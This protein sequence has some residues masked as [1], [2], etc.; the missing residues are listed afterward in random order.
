MALLS[1]ASPPAPR[2]GAR[3][4]APA[5]GPGAWPRRPAADVLALVASVAAVLAFALA[6]LPREKTKLVPTAITA[7][8]PVAPPCEGSACPAEV[9]SLAPNSMSCDSATEIVITGRRFTNAL[10]VRLDDPY[11]TDLPI[12]SG[13]ETE[14]RVRAPAGLTPGMYC[15][16]VTTPFGKNTS[17]ADQLIVFCSPCNGCPDTVNIAEVTNLNTAFTQFL[18]GDVAVKYVIADANQGRYDIMAE[19]STDGLL[20]KTATARP[21]GVHSGVTGL[22]S[23]P[24]GATFFF[25][26]DSYADLGNNDYNPVT[27][28]ITPKNRIDGTPV[29][30]KAAQ[31]NVGVRDDYPLVALSQPAGVNFGD[32]V[33][34]FALI[35]PQSRSLAYL[36]DYSPD[37]GASWLPATESTRGFSAGLAAGPLAAAPGNGAGYGFAWNSAQDLPRQRNNLVVFRVRRAAG[38][39]SAASQTSAFTVDNTLIGAASN[40]GLFGAPVISDL[41][42]LSGD[43]LGVNCVDLAA[44]D[45]NGDGRD[46]VVVADV[47][48]SKVYALRSA[49]DGSFSTADPILV[50]TNPTTQNTQPV[51]VETL[52]LGGDGFLDVVAMASL[53]SSCDITPLRG[54]GNGAFTA[55]TPIRTVPEAQ[56]TGGAY[57]QPTK[58]ITADFNGD[59]RT[60]VA[61]V[62]FTTAAPKKDLVVLLGD[63]VGGFRAPIYLDTGV[64]Q[65]LSLAAGDF[66]GDGVPDLCV[67]NWRGAPSVQVRVLIGENDGTGKGTG[68]FTPEPAAALLWD[69]AGRRNTPF[70]ALAA[71]FDASGRADIAICPNPNKLGDG[72]DE[73]VLLANDG[74]GAFTVRSLDSSSLGAGP[75][76]GIAGDLDGDGRP[77]LAFSNYASHNVAILR[78]TG[79]G[80]LSPSYQVSSAE[81]Y[82][83]GMAGGY[84]A[85]GDFN[86]DG[87][88]DL[89]VAQVALPTQGLVSVLLR[90]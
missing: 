46:D 62:T 71:D 52:Q 20:F 33:V 17:C 22:L 13:T 16:R 53:A 65:A 21:G 5:G 45:F 4:R 70:M 64:A 40:S 86:G 1:P 34:Q 69:V 79:A 88:K 11:Q 41:A 24:A 30:K 72:G 35:D 10:S 73:Y 26:W 29:T 25:V 84:L 57:N 48:T 47:S 15:L 36:A 9:L 51:H 90:K 3:S 6:C 83:V 81:T 82:D 32:V 19:Y 56:F 66:N 28:R 23:L 27:F 49:G 7:P 2:D 39:L 67:T 78:N 76:A 89:A 60:D 31:A 63:G 12:L 50:G 14:L 55:L 42:R 59:G 44:G 61:A 80:I 54:Q 74:A 68:N 18:T 85:V 77:D 8:P 75:S 58:M 38:P 87:R 43:T 37:N